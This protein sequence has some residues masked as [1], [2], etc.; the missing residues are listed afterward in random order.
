MFFCIKGKNSGMITVHQGQI[1][2]SIHLTVYP[3]LWLA[4]YLFLLNCA[5]MLLFCV[6]LLFVV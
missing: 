1:A 4:S 5:L 2:F 6:R 3:S